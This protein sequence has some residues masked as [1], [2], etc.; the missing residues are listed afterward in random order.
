M[1]RRLLP[2]LMTPLSLVDV[3]GAPATDEPPTVRVCRPP[4]LVHPALGFTAPPLP[5]LPPALPPEPE[6]A[7]PPEAWVVPPVA[8]EPPAP[9]TPPVEGWPPVPLPPVEVLPPVAE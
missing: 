5:V 6:P 3:E 2:P 4:D 8:V 1:T 7:A 9:V